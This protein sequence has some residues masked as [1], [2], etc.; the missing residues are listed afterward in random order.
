MI[1]YFLLGWIYH[2]KPDYCMSRLKFE[3]FRDK[4]YF[5]NTRKYGR[6]IMTVNNF[7]CSPF[8]HYA[9]H[10]QFLVT[11]NRLVTVD[12]LS[13]LFVMFFT[14]NQSVLF[15]IFLESQR[16]NTKLR[17]CF[18]IFK[19]RLSSIKKFSPRSCTFNQF[20]YIAVY[21]KCL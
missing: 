3:V 18:L 1:T 6:K 9:V 21:L 15:S 5:F 2:W 13:G 8:W 10:N 7:E 11:D 20:F 14:L 17:L 19:V 16:R 12:L 4:Y